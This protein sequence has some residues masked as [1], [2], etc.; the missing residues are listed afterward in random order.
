MK[1]ILFIGALCLLAACSS[2]TKQQAMSVEWDIQNFPEEN[3]CIQTIRV[4]GDLRGV[5][6][7][8]FN[9]LPARQTIKGEIDTLIELVAGYYA[10]GSPKFAAATGNDTITF[11]MY[12]GGLFPNVSLQPG[13]F[14]A[15]MN[16]GRTLPLEASYADITLNPTIDSGMAADAIYDRNEELTQGKAGIY[17][18]I[19]S[20]KKVELTGGESTIDPSKIEY[21]EI[22][23]GENPEAYK[24]TIA[25]GKIVVEAPRRQWARIGLRLRNQFGNAPIAMPNAVITDAPSMGYRGLMVDIARNFNTVEEMHKVLNLMATY[26]LNTLHFHPIDDEGWRVEI[27][28]LPELTEVGAR[29]G[30]TPGSDG[31]FI[32]QVYSGDGNPN[33]VGN[34]SNGYYTRAEFI[35]MLR[36]ADSLG[37][38]V[39]PE[40]ESP[41][42][43]RAAIKAM[44]Y[45]AKRLG[46]NSWLLNEGAAVDTSKYTSAQ[47]YHDNV[48]NPALE[49]PYR[50]MDIVA[51]EFI[52]MYREAGV[53]LPA[54]HIGGDEVAHGAWSGSPAIAAF[55][56]KEGIK[57]E[58]EIHA[59]FVRR[60]AESYAKKGI[61][62]SGWQE[63][64]LDHENDYN[65]NVAP[66][67]YSVNCWNTI[68]NGVGKSVVDRIAEAGFPIILSNVERFYLDMQYAPNPM[69]RGLNWGGWCDEFS[70][71]SGYPSKICNVKGAKIV[72]VQGQIFA[73]TIRNAGDIQRMMFPKMLG[74]AERG[75]NTE[76]TYTDADFNAAIANEL[77]KWDAA[78][79]TYHLRMPGLKVID[80]KLYANSAYANA[81]IR[82]TLDG[83]V[84]CETSRELKPGEAID[85][86][87]Y[88]DATVA[89][90]C[91]WTA[92]Q[93]SAPV[94]LP[95][96]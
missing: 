86:A 7:V 35:G 47:F 81:T 48:M 2:K 75:W 38:A 4:I 52:D 6:R 27:A 34:S 40:I 60:V 1:K 30:Y 15:V 11:E 41:G 57:T 94:V 71:L 18:A 29:R 9:Q 68:H 39:I 12:G 90:A 31:S 17:N 65:K 56:E 54:I 80:G 19:P 66:L 46:D 95:L 74:M 20:F 50:L 25:D 13:S 82:V 91:L 8:A 59:Y 28:A 64:A 85:L 88:P 23:A 3:R 37:I 36:H 32:E 67:M 24:A 44:E 33:T 63:V 89:R 96:K 76:F 62:T 16:D 43:A 14:H 22:E 10:L 58:K 78:D 21:I 92:T 79:V 83:T 87:E 5:E 51:D 53:E 69:E 93:M 84:P 77:P 73:E 26:G 72:G 70:A 42:H 45:R 49:G 61:R 55:K